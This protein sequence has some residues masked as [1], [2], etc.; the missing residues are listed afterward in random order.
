VGRGGTY[1]RVTDYGA[2]RLVG[3]P[4]LGMD[5]AVVVPQGGRTALGLLADRDADAAAGT[6]PPAAGPAAWFDHLARRG[7]VMAVTANV[8]GWPLFAAMDDAL[9]GDPWATVWIRGARAPD[10][11]ICGPSAGP[12]AG[13][14]PRSGEA[15]SA[16]G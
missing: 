12:S 9:W 1:E 5:I 2:G 10:C 14:V 8:P 15:G 3:E 16:T 6:G 4:A 13:P 11:P 7:K